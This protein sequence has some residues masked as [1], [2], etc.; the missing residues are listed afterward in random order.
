LFTLGN[1]EDIPAADLSG[2]QD[3]VVVSFSYR[4]NAFGFLSLEE[5]LLP[6]NIG[7]LDQQLALIWVYNNIDRFGGDPNQITLLGH[8]A[9][10]ASVGYHLISTSSRPYIQKYLFKTS[11]KILA[12]P[13]GVRIC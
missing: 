4:L 8:S 13:R 2:D 12:Y 1:P 10:A 9:G 3:V 7:L 11:L 6:G 5:P